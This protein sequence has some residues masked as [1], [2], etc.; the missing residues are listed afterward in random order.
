L[1]AFIASLGGVLFVWWNGPHRFPRR[2]DL[3]ATIDLLVIRRTSVVFT[4][5]D[6]AWLGAFVYVLINN[7]HSQRSPG[8]GHIGI[9]EERSIR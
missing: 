9:S 1:P 2:S 6:G 5:L 3:S 7:L 4:E 8:L